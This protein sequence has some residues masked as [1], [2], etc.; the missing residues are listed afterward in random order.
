MNQEN[1][2]LNEII[3]YH[4]LDMFRTIALIISSLAIVSKFRGGIIN[5]SL[6]DFKIIT[7]FMFFFLLVYVSKNPIKCKLKNKKQSDMFFSIG[8]MEYFIIMIITMSA[9]FVFLR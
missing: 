2:Y 4:I 9:I 6:I 7:F 8:I 3:M 1:K 5:I